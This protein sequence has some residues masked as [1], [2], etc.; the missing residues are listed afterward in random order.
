MAIES[1]VIFF[2]CGDIARTRDFYERVCGLRVAQV[3]GGGQSLIFD[4]GYGYIGFVQYGDGRPMPTGEYS[5]CISFNCRDEADVDTRYA[6][7]LAAGAEP[8]AAPA[9]H[10]VFPVYSCF[11]RDPDGYKVEFQKILSE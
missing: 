4:S 11:F 10:P 9:R 3:Q 2:P 8:I 1:S 6:E 5:P 7:V